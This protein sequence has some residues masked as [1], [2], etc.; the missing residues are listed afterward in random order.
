LKILTSFLLH[1][2]N[3]V[4]DLG[5]L[6]NK[7]YVIFLVL[8]IAALTSCSGGGSRNKDD[9]TERNTELLTGSSEEIFKRVADAIVQQNFAEVKRLYDEVATIRFRSSCFNPKFADSI[10]YNLTLPQI[11]AI[12]ATNTNNTNPD[13][14]I[15][16][17]ILEHTGDG[18]FIHYSCNNS[19]YPIHIIAAYGHYYAMSILTKHIKYYSAPYPNPIPDQPNLPPY[20]TTSPYLIEQI[21][22]PYAFKGIDVYAQH[23]DDFIKTSIKDYEALKINLNGDFIKR[24]PLY[25]AIYYKRYDIIDLLL[26]EGNIGCPIDWEIMADVADDRGGSSDRIKQKCKN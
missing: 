1:V 11:A 9:K 8:T 18:K 2:K 17:F 4:N 25:T 6:M 14:S 23:D 13:T 20:F 7:F 24:T 10:Y 22:D 19:M 3:T 12:Y 16:K 26:D 21:P 5:V 15:F